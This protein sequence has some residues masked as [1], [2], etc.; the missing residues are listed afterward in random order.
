VPKITHSTSPCFALVQNFLTSNLIWCSNKDFG[1][2]IRVESEA[3]QVSN[4]TNRNFKAFSIK[5]K[6]FCHYATV[7]FLC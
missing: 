3:F 5:I 2:I 7:F 6:T 1:V 4:S